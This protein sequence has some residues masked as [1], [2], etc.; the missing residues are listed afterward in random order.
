MDTELPPAGWYAHP[1]MAGTQ[2]Y[3]DG[4]R[5][6]D[7]IAPGTPPITATAV[8]QQTGPSDGLIVAGYITAAL[9][10]IVGFIIGCVLLPKRSSHG[11]IIMIIAVVACLFWYEQL[12]PDDPFGGRY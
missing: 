9:L 3:W 2:R 8:A 10:P 11:V 7:H 1:E 4:Q 6:T 5:W 12:T